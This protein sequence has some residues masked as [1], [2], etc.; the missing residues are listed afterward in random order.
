MQRRGWIVFA[1][2]A[3]LAACARTPPE[4]TAAELAELSNPSAQTLEIVEER[5]P[6]ALA[7]VL[8]TE[9]IALERGRPLTVQELADARGV[10]VAYPERIRLY[11]TNDLPRGRRAGEER[12]T[13]PKS[14]GGITRNYGV[15]VRPKYENAR[16]LIVHEFVHV[17]QF[18]RLG[19]EGMVRRSL[20]EQIVLRGNLS[21]IEREAIAVSEAYLGEKAPSYAF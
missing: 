15:F 13:Y 8:E 7:I 3:L 1:G 19:T 14:V 5:V 2:L 11:V 18:E 20:L 21:L 17:A 16:W 9:A 4:L 12:A 6:N 10:G